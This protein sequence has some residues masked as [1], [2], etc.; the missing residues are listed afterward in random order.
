MVGPFQAVRGADLGSME[1]AGM[2]SVCWTLTMA[3]EALQCRTLQYK[4][5]CW[6]LMRSGNDAFNMLDEEL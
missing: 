2:Y 3:C 4:S 5:S 6:R 1:L